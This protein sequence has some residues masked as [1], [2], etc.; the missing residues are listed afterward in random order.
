[1]VLRG[2][3]ADAEAVYLLAEL[4]AHR[5]QQAEVERALQR[6]PETL[7]QGSAWLLRLIRLKAILDD[8]AGVVE[9]WERHPQIHPQAK[10]DTV[11]LV[12]DAMLALGQF[13]QSQTWIEAV[14]KQ[15]TLTDFERA[16]L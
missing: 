10:A 8:H 5:G 6:L 11:A 16:K 3:P 12:S 7:R 13:E 9:L 2:R 14:L 15:P 4:L 1:M